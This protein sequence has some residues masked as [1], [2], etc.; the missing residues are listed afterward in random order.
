MRPEIGDTV[1]Y[2]DSQ[3]IEHNAFVTA[4]HG[5]DAT[6][7]LN[8]AYVSSDEK[9]CDGYGRVIQR[10]TSIVHASQRSVTQISWRRV[11]EEM[12]EMPVQEP[13]SARR[14]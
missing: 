9:K 6:P 14:R 4:V 1:T 8:L 7:A 10:A 11:D 12:P 5:S 13:S 2:R 3:G